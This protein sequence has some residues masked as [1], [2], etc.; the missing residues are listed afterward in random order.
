MFLTHPIIEVKWHN[1]PSTTK[2]AQQPTPASAL[3]AAYSSGKHSV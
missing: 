2:S 3:Y 1:V